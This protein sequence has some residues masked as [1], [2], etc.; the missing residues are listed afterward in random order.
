MIIQ[1]LLIIGFII[2][3][4]ETIGMWVPHTGFDFYLIPLFAWNFVTSPL[5]MAD[6]VF[7]K[8]QILYKRY[9]NFKSL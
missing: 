2:A 7:F 9:I 6:W 8:L 4:V 1:I 3:S 5:Q